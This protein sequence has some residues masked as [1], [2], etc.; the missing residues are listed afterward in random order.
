VENTRMEGKN[1]HIASVNI[2]GIDED[3]ILKL[4]K[5]TKYDI[6]MLQETHIGLTK[7]LN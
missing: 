4:S 5:E 3:K 1:F 2:N 6:I 7:E